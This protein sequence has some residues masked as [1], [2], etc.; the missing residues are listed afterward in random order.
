MKIIPRKVSSDIFKVLDNNYKI[1]IH[2]IFNSSLNLVINEEIINV[3]YNFDILPPMGITI[4]ED[5]FYLLK[6]NIVKKNTIKYNEKSNVIESNNIKIYLVGAREY[7]SC[8]LAKKNTIIN[9]EN[10][11]EIIKTLDINNLQCGFNMSS[12][13]FILNMLEKNESIVSKSLNILKRFF[14]DES[15]KGFEYFIGR[16][17]GLTPSGDD[18]LVGIISIMWAYEESFDKKNREIYNY[19]IENKGKLTTDISQSY[20]QNALKGKFSKAVINLVN[21][22]DSDCL[23]SNKLDKVIKFGNTSGIDLLLGII[24]GYIVIEEKI[25]L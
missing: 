3:N 21:N 23:D 25:K 12:I 16:G 4:S 9:G 2:S 22:L 20:L 17:K 13:D 10:I 24:F 5:D 6:D 15:N 19:L 8:D 11:K 14:V 18:F 7:Y 1:Y